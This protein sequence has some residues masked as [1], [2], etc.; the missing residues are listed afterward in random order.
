MNDI[1]ST[2]TLFAASDQVN[3]GVYFTGSQIDPSV[4]NLVIS[5]DSSSLLGLATSHQIWDILPIFSGLD[6]MKILG[7]WILGLVW[8]L[9]I[10][11]VLRDA[12]AR[13]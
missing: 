13:S 2:Q 10:F 9:C 8:I 7:F 5:S 12:M 1:T 3:T 11:W 6:D 4:E